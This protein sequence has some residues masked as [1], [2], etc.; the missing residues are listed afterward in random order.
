MIE[1]VKTTFRPNKTYIGIDN[2]VTGSIGII[3]TEGEYLLYHTP[4]YKE[5]N[6][7]MTKKMI[8][9]VSTV[10]LREL[11]EDLKNPFA[12]LERPM[13][14]AM[15]FSA[16]I[17][18]ARCL[19]ATLLVLDDLGIAYQYCDSKH[20]QKELLPK[21]LKKEQLKEASL[22]VGKRLFPKIRWKGFKDAD[23]LLIAEW[24]RRRG[25]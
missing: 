13:I 25:L 5:L 17:V 19:E 12:V 21:E 22:N 24:A 20:W 11:L 16:S 15:R 6:Y 10:T 4:V 18:A 2:G 23:G 8:N 9:R 1:R 14:N 3:D 7:T